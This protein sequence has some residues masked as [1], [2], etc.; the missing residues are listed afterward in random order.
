M[1]RLKSPFEGNSVVWEYVSENK[2][3]IVLFLFTTFFR[4]CPGK[5]NIK[6]LGIDK[7]FLYKEKTTDK[8]YSGEYLENVGLFFEQTSDFEEKII[9][10]ESEKV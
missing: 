8:K 6:L 4:K 2:R 9:V 3:R 1:Y 5:Q 10:L 7:N